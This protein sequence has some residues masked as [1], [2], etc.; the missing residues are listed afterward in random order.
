[1]A[2]LRQ[3]RDER[4]CL[5]AGANGPAA[6]AARAASGVRWGEG[7]RW[8]GAE[9]VGVVQ[10]RERYSAFTATSQARSTS[11]AV[12]S[13]ERVCCIVRRCFGQVLMQEMAAGAAGSRDTW[14]TSTLCC[15]AAGPGD[16]KER[17]VM[18][19]GREGMTGDGGLDDAFSLHR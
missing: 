17:W 9:R 1:M 11:G 14:R 19:K 10:R 4:L 12:W 2:F 16:A 5:L 6:N 3:I 18:Q 8:R 15:S 13:M 7:V